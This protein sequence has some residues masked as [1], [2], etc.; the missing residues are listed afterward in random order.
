MKKYLLVELTAGPWFGQVHRSE[1]M[2]EE[3]ARERNAL[4]SG[5]VIG[6]HPAETYDRQTYSIYDTRLKP[7][8]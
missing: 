1:E 8:P 5:Q 3:E 4:M 7:K 2:T 6:W